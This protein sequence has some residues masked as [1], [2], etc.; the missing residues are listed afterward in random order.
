MIPKISLTD[1]LLN[2]V[3]SPEFQAEAIRTLTAVSA[4]MLE[5]SLGEEMDADMEGMEV[6][7]IDELDP[8]GEGPSSSMQ[9]REM[10]NVMGEAGDV[11]GEEPVVAIVAGDVAGIDVGIL[12][13][14]GD[15]AVM[16]PVVAIVAGDVAGIDVG[17]LEEAGDVADME[18]A[19]D[20]DIDPASEGPS[21]PVHEYNKERLMQENE[22]FHRSQ[23]ALR[24]EE[25]QVLKATIRER[26]TEA[27]LNMPEEEVKLIAKS[28]DIYR[29]SVRTPIFSQEYIPPSASEVANRLF[30]NLSM[31]ELEIFY[32][33]IFDLVCKLEEME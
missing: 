8:A 22:E 7:G 5:T 17:I 11:A 30:K 21:T 14:A 10:I 31:E 23:A 25:H 15:V 18:P 2:I 26:K 28:D 3:Q 32:P 13:E 1:T 12:E 33:E 6:S 19:D 4:A 24:R 27:F 9:A 16:E 29:T 20:G